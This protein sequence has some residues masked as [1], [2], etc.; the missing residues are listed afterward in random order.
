MQGL[1]GFG[2]KCRTL[3][4]TR[5]VGRSNIPSSARLLRDAHLGSIGEGTSNIVA[6]D[7]LRA[8]QREGSRGRRLAS[9]S[10]T[11]LRICRGP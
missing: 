11:L 8:A 9:A 3:L 10:R 1:S 7:V 2:A 4:P 5:F 6:L